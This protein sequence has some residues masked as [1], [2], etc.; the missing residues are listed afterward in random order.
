MGGLLKWAV[1]ITWAQPVSTSGLGKIDQ[2][3]RV[4]FLYNSN[5]DLTRK[6]RYTG[7]LI[8]LPSGEPLSSVLNESALSA[9]NTK[10]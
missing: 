9:R 4:D 6:V 2:N 3:E 1:Q 8:W 10:T 5:E 7:G